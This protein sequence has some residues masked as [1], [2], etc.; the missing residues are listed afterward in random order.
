MNWIQN[1]HRFAIIVGLTLA[2]PALFVLSILVDF[3]GVRQGY[4]KD[5][6]RLEP[7]VARLQ[8]L[9]E[10][11]EQLRE[12]SARAEALMQQLVSPG[13]EDQA[14]IAAALQK[15]VRDIF[16]AAGFQ[17]GNSRILPVK[18]EEGLER[19]GLSLTV[20]GELRA[21]DKALVEL[22]AYEP[23][24]L[25]EFIEIKPGSRSRRDKGPE[26]QSVVTTLQLITLRATM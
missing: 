11:E 18:A 12:S 20:S 9:I 16:L 4:Q 5:I 1:N 7:R 25:V 19:V 23:V 2:V 13:S 14:R 10:S 8:G 24:L 15:N 26:V 22:A 3:W 17:V 21:L 6:D